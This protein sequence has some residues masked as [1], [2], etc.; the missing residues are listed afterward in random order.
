MPDTIPTTDRLIRRPEVER[1]TAMSASSIY[2]K[3]K[4]GQFPRPRKIGPGIQGSV[5]WRESE[6]R[7]WVNRLPVST[8]DKPAAELK[9]F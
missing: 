2:R 9:D 3:M 1:M 4:L 8:G 6:V 5:A 7:E